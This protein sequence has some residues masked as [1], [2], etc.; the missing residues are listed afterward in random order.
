MGTQLFVSIKCAVE[1]E[2]GLIAH[3]VSVTMLGTMWQL[4]S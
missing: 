2:R 3:Y 1:N 4:E